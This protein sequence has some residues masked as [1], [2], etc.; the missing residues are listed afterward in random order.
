[1]PKSTKSTKPAKS[2]QSAQPAQPVQSTQSVQKKLKPL[3]GQDRVR[4]ARL[5]E[6]I[7]GNV[8]EMSTIM[9]RLHGTPVSWTK[10]R[11]SSSGAAG[12]NGPFV[13]TVVCNEETGECGCYDHEGGTCGPCPA[14][15]L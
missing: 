12:T 9:N 8:Q 6:K 15:D 5:F 4:M 1:M 3:K 11:I 10:F 7:T 2:E 14:V 13:I